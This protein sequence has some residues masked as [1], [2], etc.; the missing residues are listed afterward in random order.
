LKKIRLGT[1]VFKT[2]LNADGSINKYKARLVVK[3]YAQI[4]GVDYFDTFAS[5]ARQDTI[6]MLLA[7]ATQK[8]WKIYQLHV[9]SA[10]LNGFLEEEIFVEQPKGFFVKGHEDKVYLLKKALYGLKQAPRAWYN[11]IDEFLSKLG[12]VKSLSESTLYIKGNQA[13]SI[14]ISL[15][16]DDL[17][18]TGSNAKL[19]QQFK[20]DMLQVFEMTDLGEMTYFLGM[21]VKQN[22]G[23]IFISQ[24]KY[25]KEILKKFNMENCKSM[26]TPMC[27]KEK[28][29]KDDVS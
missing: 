22:D 12:F 6:R 11:K 9:K 29:C 4:F 19:I 10:S 27:Q 2:K 16:V 25:A 26:N 8:G 5:V 15:Y 14:V 7:I 24:R 18:V 3:G 13:N 28:L 20:D 21:E 23:E 1:W 17:L